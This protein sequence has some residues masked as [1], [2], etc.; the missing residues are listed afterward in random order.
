MIQQN[1]P[2]EQVYSRFSQIFSVLK[3]SQFLRQA[4]IRKSC[5]FSCFVVFQYLFQLV[6]QGQNL[7]R[8]LEGRRAENMPGKDV[9]YRFL[10]EPRFN[11][12]RFYQLLVQKVV[13]QFETLTSPKRVRVFVID[14]S[15]VSRDRS[16]KVELLARVYDHV[17]HRFIRGFQL[18]TLGW[19]DGFSFVPLDFSLMSSAK[20]ENRYNEVR[21]NLD[22]RF[23]GYARRKEALLHKP[24]V[25]TQMVDRALQAGMVADYILMDSWF[26]YMPLVQSMLEKGMHV[27]GR[28]KDTKQKYIYQEKMLNLGELYTALPKQRDKR[29]ILGELRV[30]SKLGVPLKIVFV[31]NRNKSKEW[32]AILTTDITLEADETVRI[33]GMRWSIEPF[34]KTIKSLLKLENEFEGRSYDMMI[35]HTTIV[36]SRYLILEWERRNNNDDRTF[37]GIFFEYCDEV[38]DMDLM[39]ALRQLMVFV[40]ALMSKPDDQDGVIRQVLDW[41]AQLPNYIRAS[42]PLSLCES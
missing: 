16:K 26:T 21:D 22:K 18:L 20:K 37:G 39:T 5:G 38:K 32:I 27:I 34:H 31:R 8:I 14:D 15:P 25:V 7:Y 41:I 42:L 1:A 36:F 35:S 23:C 17:S 6:F 30:K 19:S 13:G 9:Y 2:S 10:N 29:Q 40:F 11:W 28:I 3:V 12:R 24:E 33:Y 4:G